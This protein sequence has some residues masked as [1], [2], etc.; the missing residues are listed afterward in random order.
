M[1]NW[2]KTQSAPPQCQ[3]TCWLRQHNSQS[4]FSKRLLAV[5]SY[6]LASQKMAFYSSGA[7]N[8]M[9]LNS[10]TLVIRNLCPFA[11]RIARVFQ[12]LLIKTSSCGLGKDLIARRQPLHKNLHCT[13]HYANGKLSGFLLARHHYLHLVKMLLHHWR[14]VYW[15]SRVSWKNTIRQIVWVTFTKTTS[16]LSHWRIKIWIAVKT[17]LRI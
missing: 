11:P 15:R 5:M 10:S 12:L 8:P 13:N 1:A 3:S 17:T 16:Q 7:T 6:R 9:S 2:A 4:S 14:M